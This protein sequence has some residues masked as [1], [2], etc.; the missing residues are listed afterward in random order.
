MTPAGGRHSAVAG[1]TTRLIDEFTEA[2]DLGCGA[3]ESGFILRRSP[4]VVRAPTCASSPKLAYPRLGFQP[5]TGRSPRI[6]QWRSCRLRI[7]LRM[8][9]SRSR[10]TSGGRN[11]F[12][13]CGRARDVHGA[14]LPVATRRSGVRDRRR[15]ERRRGSARLPVRGAAAVSLTRDQRQA[16]CVSVKSTARPSAG[17]VGR[18]RRSHSRKVAKQRKARRSATVRQLEAGPRR[19]RCAV[20]CGAGCL[21]SRSRLGW[22]GG[23]NRSFLCCIYPEHVQERR[24]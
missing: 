4:D 11:A 12:G 9:T 2:R 14:R 10:S 1:R 23:R 22:P 3:A 6:S 8:S 17:G 15:V 18:R 24:I 16:R 5:R 7:A 20:V 19:S 13:V 21:S